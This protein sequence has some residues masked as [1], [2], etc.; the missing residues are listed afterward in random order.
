VFF[1]PL[2]STKARQFVLETTPR[3]SEHTADDH[4]SDLLLLVGRWV[5]A[6]VGVGRRSLPHSWPGPLCAPTKLRLLAILA[7]GRQIEAE[8][9]DRI[10]LVTRI[11]FSF[12]GAVTRL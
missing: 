3:E 5:T 4:R 1:R 11:L 2:C 6:L 8:G 10:V 12:E 7:G 9:L